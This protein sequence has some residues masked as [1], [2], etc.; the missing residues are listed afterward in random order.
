MTQIEHEVNGIKILVLE[1]LQRNRAYHSINQYTKKCSITSFF[2]PQA[3]YHI[4]QNFI[5][6]FSV[7]KSGVMKGVLS[8]GQLM[9][10][11]DFNRRNII[12]KDKC[13]Q[14]RV[15]SLVKISF[16]EKSVD[17]YTNK[18]CPK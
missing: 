6:Y 9:N 13:T 17:T 8:A 12:S 3:F 4:F 1:C 7:S 15:Y 16:W 5:H 14:A 10:C 18:S 11:L 2:S